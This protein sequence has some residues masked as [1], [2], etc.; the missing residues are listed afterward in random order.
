MKRQLRKYSTSTM[1]AVPPPPPNVNS[2]TL[3]SR[4][5]ERRS[6]SNSDSSVEPMDVSS[7]INRTANSSTEASST[8]ASSNK[9]SSDHNDT[10][11][12]NDSESEYTSH[13]VVR[14]DNMRQMDT[15]SIMIMRKKQRYATKNNNNVQYGFEEKQRT[16]AE[17][18]EGKTSSNQS[19]IERGPT[20]NIGKLSMGEDKKYFCPICNSLLDTQHEF[21][22]HI[23]SHNNCDDSTNFTCRICSKVLSSASSLDRHVLVH[24]GERPFTCKYCHVTFTTNGNMHRHMRT[25]KQRGEGESY[26]SDG[27]TDSSGSS[28]NNNY[29]K[30]TDGKR[31]SS[32]IEDVPPANHLKRKIRTIN[33]N[34]IVEPATKIVPQSFCCP[35]CDRNDFSSML[36]LEQHMDQEHPTVPAKCRFC[37]VVFKS[38]KLLNAHRCTSSRSQNIMQG[39]KDLTFVDF[40]SEKFPLIAKSVC[41]QSIRTPIASQK[42][43]CSK[44]YRA[45][46]CASAVEIHA[47]E[48]GESV[49]DFSIRRNRQNSETSEE[50]AKRDDFFANLDLQNKSMTTTASTT[51]SGALTPQSSPS[52]TPD[53]DLHMDIKEEMLRTPTMHHQDSKDLADIQSIINVTSSGQFLRQLE[54]PAP[55][56]SIDLNLSMGSSK[57]EE[58]A[59]DAFTAEFRKMKLRGEFPCKLCTAVFPNLRALKGH[60]RIH[61]SAAGAGPYRCNMCPYTI[62]DKAAL[63]RHMRTHNGDRP[64]ECAMCNYAFT[65]KANCERHLRNR[66]AKSTREEVKRAI[67]YHPSEDSSCDDPT[68]KLQLFGSPDFP[69]DDDHMSKDRTS[70]PVSHLKEMLMPTML[71]GGM[72][73]AGSEPPM[74]I[75]VKSL[76]K[77]IHASSGYDDDEDDVKDEEQ[78]EGNRDVGKPVDLS[79][80]ALDLSKKSTSSRE[81][82]DSR[83]SPSPQPKIDLA[84]F[85]KNQQLLF[86]QQQQLLNET[87]PKIDPAHYIQLHQFYQN[88]MFHQPGFPL[89]HFLLQNSLLAGQAAAGSNPMMNMKNFFQPPKDALQAGTQ[90]PPSSLLLNPMF[91]AAASSPPLTNHLTSQQN[92]TGGANHSASAPKASDSSPKQPQQMPHI[93][94]PH[95]STGPV[96]MVIKNGVLMPKQKQ[97][98]YRTE[99][100]FACEHCSARFTLRSNMERHIKQQHPQFWAQRQRSGHNMM[101]RGGGAPSQ[102]PATPTTNNHTVPSSPMA[103][104]Q[105]PSSGTFGAISEHVKYAILAQQLKSRD[106]SGKLPFLPNIP[107]GL[108]SSSSASSRPSSRQVEDEEEDPQLVIDED[109]QPEDLSQMPTTKVDDEHILAA[110]KVA[111]NILEQ[112][113]KTSSDK[114]SPS[115]GNAPEGR[116]SNGKIKAENGTKTFNKENLKEEADLVSVSRLVDNATNPMAFGNYFRSDANSQEHSDEEGLVASGSASESNNS[117]TDDPNPSPVMQKKKSAYSLAPNRVS[118][119]YCQRMFPWSSSLRRHILT[120]TGQKP[121]KCSHCPLLFTTKSNCDRHLLR[122]HGNVESAMS[123]YV[124][125]DD[126]LDPTKITKEDNPSSVE[127]APPKSPADD[128][129]SGKKATAPADTCGDVGTLNLTVPQLKST[130]IETLGLI[131]SDLPFK[132]HLC[133]GSFPERVNCLEH[134]KNVHTQEFALLLSKGAI[135]AEAEAQT[136]S[137]EDDEKNEAKGKY[138]DYTNRKVICA[139]CMRRFWSTEDLRRHMRTHSGERPFQC[140]V[141]QRKFT[142]KHSMLRHQKKHNIHGS[143]NN[144]PNSAHSAS[145][146]SDDEATNPTTAPPPIAANLPN[147]LKIPEFM[148]WKLQQQQQQQQQLKAQEKFSAMTEGNGAS[149]LGLLMKQ[150]HEQSG[151][152]EASDLIGNLLGISD[153]G[154]LNKVLQSSPDEAAK[155]LGVEK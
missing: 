56:K 107:S 129:A 90:L 143:G 42:F 93:P 70:T 122:K 17:E 74:K 142:L 83:D 57:D 39:F 99:R 11:Q 37:D 45:F 127:E 98:R 54:R 43:E 148:E 106:P 121:F 68:K 123:L 26:E 79:M 137:A 104:T 20:E 139:F 151:E 114:T 34:N 72:A 95:Q 152:S 138:P 126:V 84:M 36:Y 101:R 140:D 155:L 61:L 27:S 96:K 87:F 69:D 5:P 7:S 58:E 108:M 116:D 6:S 125:I 9:L 60:N 71:P 29:Q 150:Q 40:S 4:T 67:I 23:R 12:T 110:K 105:M 41:E 81:E 8:T 21:T 75:Q 88:L 25:H 117:G 119:P 103:G 51:S 63:I 102:A 154:I 76:E 85:E 16:D 113:M 144:Q 24:T 53:D 89:Q 145:D 86:A 141:C 128:A 14:R 59:Q 132:C 50:E 136:A 120:H 111:E 131:S 65:T 33:N 115:Q 134:I 19:P 31:K 80:D 91:T 13:T 124:P 32:E 49:Q 30:R 35:V 100:P 73:A 3:V 82:K 48:C 109:S 147:L 78:T 112:A 2:Q 47:K 97:R 38:Y 15:T 135:E 22:E 1:S 133:D 149:I 52:P 28:S 18:S 10:D 62:H 130:A 77:L 66:H 44:C 146:L 64:Y 46:P 153:K 118:C 55:S 92:S 94:P